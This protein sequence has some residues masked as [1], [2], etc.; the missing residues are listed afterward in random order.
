[1][2]RQ[3]I[4]FTIIFGPVVAVVPFRP[5]ELASDEPLGRLLEAEHELEESLGRAG[6]RQA[7][8]R[9][10]LRVPKDMVKEV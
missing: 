3:R 8:H 6:V 4:L 7:H 2:P 1:M 5:S 9:A 10:D